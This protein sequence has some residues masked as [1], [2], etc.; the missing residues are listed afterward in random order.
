MNVLSLANRTV[1]CH[2]G[3][4][5][6]AYA[7]S[8]PEGGAE[9]NVILLHGFCGSSAY[10]EQ[11]LPLISK[12]GR[13]IIVPDARGHGRSSSPR[14]DVY[15]MEIMADDVAALADQLGI[16]RFVVLGHSMGGYASLALAERHADR[17]LG[18]GLVHSTG[19]PDGEAAKGNRDRAVKKIAEEGI[20]KFAEGLVP[21]L[22]APEAEARLVE[23][24]IQIGHQ[25]SA[26]GAQASALGMKE[27][28][29]RR[30]V[31]DSSELPVLLVAGKMDGVIPV[32]RTFTSSRSGVRQE[33]LEQAG[34][35]GMIET[36]QQM[37]DAVSGYL[38]LIK[39]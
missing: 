20:E 10:W 4:L 35:M 38:D 8:L 37:A 29:D 6:I 31:I 12:P 23:H 39:G 26:S 9:Q 30:S 5:T 13:R 3:A 21:N 33:L 25:T 28:P 14:S 18:F 1:E 22:F 34:H 32:E 36:P 19:Y 16:A 24:A 2:N 27:R 7:D 17:L 15:S 11:L